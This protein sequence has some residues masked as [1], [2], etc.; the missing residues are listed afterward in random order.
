MSYASEDRHYAAL[1]E[2]AL[3][4]AG[5]KIIKA[6]GKVNSSKSFAQKLN[7]YIQSADALIVLISWATLKSKW[8]RH[9]VES[10]AIQD[11]STN[12]KKIIP[13][14]LDSSPM[15][16]YLTNYDYLDSTSSDGVIEKLIQSLSTG[17]KKDVFE[18]ASGAKEQNTLHYSKELSKKLK[19]G[20]LTLVC[21]AGV[22]IGA[23][24]PTW[25]DLLFRLLS[26]MIRNASEAR[27]IPFDEA[28][29]FDF[30]KDYAPSS[31]IL[32]KYL[33]NHFGDNFLQEVRN[34]LY[35]KK[36][37]RCALIDSIVDLSRPQ[38]ASRSLDSIITFN[39]D[40]LI[41]ENLKR[42]NVPYR[43]I[44]KEGMT[45]GPNELPIYHVHGYLPKAGPLPKD[46]D[47]VFSED[48]Y[49]T[50]FIEPFSWS[51]LI[52]L[53]KLNENTCL[54]IG[55]SF[56]DPNLRRLLDVANRKKGSSSPA[57]YIIKKSL[58]STEALD[59]MAKIFEEQDA[60]NLGLKTIWVDEYSEIPT[61][62][63]NI[64]I[65]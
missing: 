40:S 26:S 61:F 17:E 54:F 49:H 36:T 6:T 23:G 20:R 30:Q 37:E 35:L 42:E 45:H 44:Y 53:I 12:E 22:S 21:G 5:H 24:I 55:L 41:E 38:R 56:T 18:S 57:H 15:P 8:I 47:I 25:D 29:V 52:Q 43:T 46:I 48:S 7:R 1:L 16:S 14:K 3:I 65:S 39:F 60:R 58:S 51:N 2:N 9:E 27:S 11:F 28:S 31:L 32:G 4:K 34:S 13:I 62:L 33:K 10:M 64:A 19:T 59:G 50:Q 63:K